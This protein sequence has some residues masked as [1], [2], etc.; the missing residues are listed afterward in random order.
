MFVFLIARGNN[1]VLM[2]VVDLVLLA[3]LD[4]NVMTI[5]NVNVFQTA[6]KNNVDRMD[7]K[8][9]VVVAT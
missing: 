7:V 1:A 4:S 6:L 5:S 8:D 9:L 2:A 3:K